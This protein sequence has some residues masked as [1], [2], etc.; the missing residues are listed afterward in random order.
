MET[1]ES[2]EI[3]QHGLVVKRTHFE[4]KQYSSLSLAIENVSKNCFSSRFSGSKYLQAFG[5]L[6]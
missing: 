5:I 6:L 4:K 1:T 3:G 2:Y